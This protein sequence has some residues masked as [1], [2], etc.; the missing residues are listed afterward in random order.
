MT[1][2]GL[3]LGQGVFVVAAGLGFAG[4]VACPE[5]VFG[6][7]ATASSTA[8]GGSMASYVEAGRQVFR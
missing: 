4:I 1:N 2:G 3:T 8:Y 7:G 6:G 5:A